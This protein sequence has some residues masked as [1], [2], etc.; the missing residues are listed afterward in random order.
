MLKKTQAERPTMSEVAARLAALLEA[1]QM[2]TP[3]PSMTSHEEK[4]LPAPPPEPEPQRSVFTTLFPRRG[5]DKEPGRLVRIV[6]A[7]VA[8][9]FFL[10]SLLLLILFLLKQR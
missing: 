9:G 6:V 5:D 10:G 8:A 4:H 2:P 1:H 7:T 3:L